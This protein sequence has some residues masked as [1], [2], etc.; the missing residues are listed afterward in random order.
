MDLKF[1][2]VPI[3]YGNEELN[4]I[5]GQSHFIKT[6]EDIYESLVTSMPGIK[7]GVAFNE[8][9]GPCLIRKDGTDDELINLAVNNAKNIGAGHIFIIFLKDA[10]PINVLNRLKNIQEICNI[11]VAT[12]NKVEVIVAESNL[13]RGIM[14]VIDGMPPKGIETEKDTENRKD[15][16]RNIVKYKK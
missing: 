7:F 3:D 6:V 10:Y 11:Y 8:A 1:K 4:V 12:A 14:G 9:S 15:F 2:K 16:L 5:I 13:G